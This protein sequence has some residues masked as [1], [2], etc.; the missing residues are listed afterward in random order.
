MK[1]ERKSMFN[2]KLRAIVNNVTFYRC[3]VI[4]FKR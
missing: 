3:F 4:Y 2:L 1:R